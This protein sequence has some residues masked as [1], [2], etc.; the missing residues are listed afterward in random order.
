MLMDDLSQVRMI[1]AAASLL[2][3]A[4]VKDADMQL[5]LQGIARRLE[6]LAGPS[7]PGADAGFM[8]R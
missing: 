1:R 3:N 8:L 6:E 4:T 5:E 2:R 7:D